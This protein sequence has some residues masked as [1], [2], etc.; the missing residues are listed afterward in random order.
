MKKFNLLKVSVLAL[1]ALT[2]FSACSGSGTGPEKAPADVVKDGINNLSDVKSAEYS[3]SVKGKVAVDEANA[4][5]AGFANLDIDSTFSGV[6]DLNDTEDAK[7]SLAMAIGLKLDDGEDQKVDAEFRFIKDTA[8]LMLSDLSDF[9]GAVPKEMVAAFLKQ[10][11][12]MAIPE[13][14][15][16]QL[17]DAYKDEANMTDQ[18]KQLKDLYKNT[19]M[20]KDVEYIKT[21]KA[22]GVNAYKYS[23]KLDKEA[24]QKYLEEVTKIMGNDVGD[25]QM[26]DIETML[27]YMD[28]DGYIWVGQ[29]DMTFR[30]F[31]GT[32]NVTDAEGVSGDIDAT[33]ELSN[34]GSAVKLVAPEDATEFNP[35]MLLGGGL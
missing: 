4:E 6:Y 12:S 20:M 33:Y 2:V 22:G 15:L 3:F 13:E 11:W 27:G 16:S 17:K 7:F 28:S 30:K 10:W 1:S 23:V 25:T 24:V 34:L 9:D 35:M 32:I 18:E 19:M 31:S 8:Y 26:G 5:N 21:E 29:D 14:S